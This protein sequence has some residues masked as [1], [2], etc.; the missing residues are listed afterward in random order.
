MMRIASWSCRTGSGFVAHAAALVALGVLVVGTRTVHAQERTHEEPGLPPGW[1]LR[2]DL[3]AFLPVSIRTD[4]T[5]RDV[6][7]EADANAG[8]VLDALQAA[9]FL[10]VEV[11][12]KRI[13][14]ISDTGYL[15]L[16]KSDQI[17][18]QATPVDV[19]VRAL[20]S[21]LMLAANVL[22]LGGA[23]P[24]APLGIL[25]FDAGVRVQ[26]MD[27]E[28][29]VGEARRSGNDETV[30]FVGAVQIPVRVA[31]RMWIRT[32]GTVAVPEGT[33]VTVQSVAEYD[34][35]SVG[36]ALGYRF[37]S[38]K[39]DDPHVNVESRAH[40]VYVAFAAQFGDEG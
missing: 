3:Y 5:I 23:H 9:G 8:D 14:L 34:F 36:L 24:G 30:R 16:G 28:V 7:A 29:E 25:E 13:G 37:D 40:S 38:M 21:D 2:M 19:D 27:A 11:W 17:G 10:R 35:G 39:N 12:R 6:S 4:V 22:Q 26:F 1:L 20:T 32:R 18:P 15:Q 31:E 33:T